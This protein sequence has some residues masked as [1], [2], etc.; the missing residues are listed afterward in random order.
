MF[1]KVKPMEKKNFSSKISADIS[2]AEAIEKINHV[3]GWW[4]GQH[5]AKWDKKFENSNGFGFRF[6]K[7]GIGSFFEEIRSMDQKSIR[8]VLQ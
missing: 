2:A 4:D 7:F 5:N 8:T 6:C 1:K 3:P